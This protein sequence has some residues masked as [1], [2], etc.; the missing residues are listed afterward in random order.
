[1]LEVLLLSSF[2]PLSFANDTTATTPGHELRL[3]KTTEIGMKKE[4]LRISPTQ[5]SVD[6]VFKNESKK[7]IETVVAFP[8]AKF[9]ATYHGSAGGGEDQFTDFEV[10]VDHKKVSYKTQNKALFGDID[11]A[12]E[13][14][15]LKVPTDRF[16]ESRELLPSTLAELTKKKWYST[17]NADETLS[18]MYQ[19]QRTH[20][21]SQKFTAGRDI[22]SHHSYTPQLGDNSLN[23]LNHLSIRPYGPDGTGSQERMGWKGFFP[24]NYDPNA[25]CSIGRNDSCDYLTD[26]WKKQ[27]FKPGSFEASFYKYILS[28]GSNWK[29][30]IEDFDL[31]IE[32]A[33]VIFVEIDRMLDFDLGSYHFHMKNF[34]PKD[35]LLIEFVGKGQS[36]NLPVEIPLIKEINGPANCRKNANGETLVS[37]PDKEKVTLRERNKDWYRILYKKQECW[38]HRKNLRFLPQA[39]S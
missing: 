35:E 39:S 5:V 25:H 15:K 11:I 24:D 13:L 38:T 28:T 30:G 34:K 7:D 1:M 26:S 27:G 36:P 33:A 19:I 4:R 12:P 9:W 37:L 10:H 18:A 16:L 6:Y 8:L 29:N 14:E 20:Y 31:S 22:Q 2:I 17:E 3:E 23:M 21:W 32:G